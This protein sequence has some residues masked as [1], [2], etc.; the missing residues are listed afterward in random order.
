M[1][2]IKKCDN[3]IHRGDMM[4][5]IERY[6]KIVTLL[7]KRKKI[8]LGD[9]ISELKISE[10]TARRDLTFL[11]KKGKLKRV[12]GGAI[13]IEKELE[14]DL[15]S[16]KRVN[17][18]AKEI[19]AKKASEYVK[20]GD[21]LFLDAGSTTELLIKYLTNKKDI[22][23]VTNGYTHIQELIN[24]GIES[25]LLGG[26]IKNTTGAIVGMTAMFTL[27]NYN[28]DIVFIGA[29]AIDEK[30]YS[31]SDSEEI[32]VKTEAISRG[33]KVYFLCDTSKLNKKSFIQFASLEDGILITEKD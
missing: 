14:E 6:E 18:E 28:F 32:L 11:E 33:E 15:D 20:D 1:N 12:H 26:R 5:S 4:L 30:G 31:T 2:K 21:T 22:K 8:K 7:E 29:N 9:I 17:L 23:V 13:L 19:I 16:K 25:Y 3:I 10:A 24:Y 27:K